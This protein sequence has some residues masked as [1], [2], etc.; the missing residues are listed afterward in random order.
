MA[1]P[2]SG[3]GGDK[4]PMKLSGQ[5]AGIKLTLVNKQDKVIRHHSSGK[6]TTS[7]SGEA[8]SAGSKRS[9][10]DGETCRAIHTFSAYLCIPILYMTYDIL[11]GAYTLKCK[12]A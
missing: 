11:P 6:R 5:K 2:V 8:L 12:Y 7:G 10:N 9:R 1:R 4:D 3:G